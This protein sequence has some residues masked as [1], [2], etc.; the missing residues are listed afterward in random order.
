[1]I[2]LDD[3]DMPP[4][5][6]NCISIQQVALEVGRIASKDSPEF[7]EALKEYF[8]PLGSGISRR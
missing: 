6:E 7:Q 4:K 3:T 2:I 8:T 5:F 1:M